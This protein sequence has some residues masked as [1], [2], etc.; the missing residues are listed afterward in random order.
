MSY[1][2]APQTFL[3]ACTTCTYSSTYACLIDVAGAHKFPHVNTLTGAWELASSGDTLG[4]ATAAAL[5]GATAQ[6]DGSFITASGGARYWL[7]EGR[8]VA[9]LESW[10]GPPP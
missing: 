3:D 6:A 4:S 5:H 9:V 1:P 8:G 2:S 10:P 7:G